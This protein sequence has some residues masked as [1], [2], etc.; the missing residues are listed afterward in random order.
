MNIPLQID[1]WKMKCPF[2]MV[3]FQGIFV[4]FRGVP[5]REQVHIPPNWKRTKSSTQKCQLGAEMLVSRQFEIIVAYSSVC[6][7]IHSID[8]YIV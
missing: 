4:S 1:A 7:Y 2:K 5:R 6:K 3:P 8:I